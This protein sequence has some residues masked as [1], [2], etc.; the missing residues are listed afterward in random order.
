MRDGR[1]VGRKDLSAA[2]AAKVALGTEMHGSWP[3][4]ARTF[5]VTPAIAVAGNRC[6]GAVSTASPRARL[7]TPR[8]VGTPDPPHVLLD[9][10]DLGLETRGAWI[11]AARILFGLT[12]LHLVSDCSGLVQ[13]GSEK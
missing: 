10:V 3:S 13:R 5:P 11:C 9:Q 2:R 12:A 4:L 8:E 6:D 7:P 1:S